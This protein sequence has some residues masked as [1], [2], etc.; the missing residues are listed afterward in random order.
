M[1]AGCLEPDTKLPGN[2]RKGFAH[3][4]EANDPRLRGCEI[5]E[6]D[7]CPLIKPWAVLRI[8]EHDK[9]RRLA[10]R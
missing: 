3:D 10:G 2:R 9:D 4:Q 7:Q 8:S 5:E 6:S 1:G